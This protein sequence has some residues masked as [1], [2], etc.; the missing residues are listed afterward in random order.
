MN[1]AMFLVNL[2]E[3]DKNKWFNNYTTDEYSITIYIY[4][5]YG[6]SKAHLNLLI[7]EYIL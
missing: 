6:K 4:T 5:L 2:E 1:L 7:S 3:T